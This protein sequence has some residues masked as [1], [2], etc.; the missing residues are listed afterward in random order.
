MTEFET[1]M[2]SAG[3]ALLALAEG[4]GVQAAEA[5]EAAFGQAG[6]RIEQSLSQ[7]A[8]TGEL[9]SERMAEAILRDLARVAAEAVVAMSG[10]SGTGAGAGQTV[11]MNMSFGAGANA[12]SVMQSRGALSTALASAA[13]AGGRFL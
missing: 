2:A 13:A 1:E 7:A 5:L 6:A 9:D 4:P 12:S 11:N 10:L 8:R 3:D